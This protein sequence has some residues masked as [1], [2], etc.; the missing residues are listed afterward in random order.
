MRPFP[1][2]LSVLTGFILLL[3]VLIANTLVTRQQFDVQLYHQHWVLHTQQVRYEL[4]QTESLLT[5]A[6]TGQRGFLY[7]GDSKYLAPYDI[8]RTQATAQLDQLAQL[9]VDNP[10]QQAR[11]AVLRDLTA[12]KLD[13]LARTISLYQSGQTDA[14][15]ALVES[16]LGLHLM[17]AVRGQI[18]ALE[19]E[20]DALAATRATAYQHSVH[21]TL[22]CIYLA[23]AIAAIGLIVLAFYILRVMDI[24]ER[25]ARLLQEREEWFRV[26]L[27]SLGDAVVATD[28]HG[29]V[30]FMNSIAEKI[31]GYSEKQGLGRPVEKIMPLSN[32]STGLPVDNP[33]QK[34]MQEGRIVGLANH[35]VLESSD[36]RLIPI[37]DSAAPIRNDYGKMVGVV[38]VFRDATYERKTQDMLRRSEKLAAAGRLASTVAHEINNPL[39]AVGNLIYIVRHTPGLPEGVTENLVMAEQELERVSHITRQTLG[40]YRESKVPESVDLSSVVEGVLRIYSNKF[41]AKNISVETDLQPCP[42][43]QGLPGEMK[44]AMSNLVSNAA[45]A[46]NVNGRIRVTMHC[47]EEEHGARVHV[48][49]EDDGPGIALADRDRISDPFFTTKKDVGTGLGLWVTKEI[50]TRHGGSIEA[51][52]NDPAGLG[53]ASFHVVIPC[54]PDLTH[55]IR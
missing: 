21:L 7:T 42:P 46:V 26:T 35:T 2:R 36:G 14:A 12:K 40:F 1:R 18:A 24:R 32:E 39:E 52:S 3:I 25:H 31:T 37:E 4:S 15:R 29:H 43:I 28:E 44:Q 10:G 54:I 16:D 23:S 34:V 53:G 22:S 50:L 41:K 20:E 30:T 33:V 55:P 9:T 48:A 27:T 13:E 51:Q 47:V 6:E 8:A 19:S 11:I 17:E 5:D 45:D 49:V 38:L